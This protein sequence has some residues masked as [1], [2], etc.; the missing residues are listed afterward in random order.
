MISTLL[1]IISDKARIHPNK[2]SLIINFC[3]KKVDY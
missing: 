1:A 2:L 3:I